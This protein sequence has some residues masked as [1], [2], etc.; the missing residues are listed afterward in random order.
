M[1]KMTDPIFCFGEMLW[2]VLPGGRRP[3]GAPMNV[4]YHLSRF[5]RNAFPISAVGRDPA[6][7]AL[8]D[9]LRRWKV[10]TDWVARVELLPT[11][12]VFAEIDDTGNATYEIV[13]P[14][15]W[16]AIPISD[17]LLEQVKSASAL[18][19]GSLAQRREE[20]QRRLK[21]VLHTLPFNS[22]RVF[23]VNLRP[24]F[25]DL[26][27]VG[28][29]ARHA[30]VLKVNH[31]EAARLGGHSPDAMEENARAMAS[32]SESA[33]ICVTAG[34]GGAGILSKNVWI[35]E[36]GR[37]VV[38]GDTVGAGDS[39]L[40]ALIDGLLGGKPIPEILKRACRV[41]EFVATQ[42]GATPAYDPS[43]IA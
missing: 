26:Q 33:L 42:T 1:R 35:F 2:D 43:G 20:N 12:E 15:A 8:L 10:P 40:A 19:F 3:G 14:S 39:F 5:G 18:V 41:G 34:R 13:E 21:Q 25:D 27:L 22:L 24:P 36:E 23:D 7:D 4:A 9:H 29:L 37:D 32:T 30:N 16:D 11:G 31:D 17:T 28:R 6:G 38:V